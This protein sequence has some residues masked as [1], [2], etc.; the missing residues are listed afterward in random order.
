MTNTS[1]SVG[2]RTTGGSR[3]ACNPDGRTSGPLHVP[4]EEP[5]P[6]GDLQPIVQRSRALNDWVAP[7]AHQPDA[8]AREVPPDPRGRLGLVSDPGGPG[9]AQLRRETLEHGRR[10]S[11][12]IPVSRRTSETAE[13]A[14]TEGH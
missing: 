2:G 9:W 7:A 10:S 11:A 13:D 1:P 4:L 5:A 6:S 12:F 14:A 8:S 3:R